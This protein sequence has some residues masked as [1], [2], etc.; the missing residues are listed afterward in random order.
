MHFKN[1]G[2]L[3]NIVRVPVLAAVVHEIA[4]LSDPMLHATAMPF[5]TYS[6]PLKFLQAV[7]DFDPDWVSEDWHI[8]IKLRL[9]TV[10]RFPVRPIFLP[11]VNYGVEDET[12][13]RT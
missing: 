12:C 8:G 11:V 1:Y 5:S 4:V 6:I 10:G 13:L 2:E 9:A 3:P 7:G